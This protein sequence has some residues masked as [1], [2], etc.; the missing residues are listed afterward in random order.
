VAEGPLKVATLVWGVKQSFRNYVQGAGGAIETHGGVVCVDGEFVFAASPDGGLSRDSA[1]ALH[2]AQGFTGE[3]AFKAH[4]G[5]LSVR[6]IDPAVEITEAGAVLSAADGSKPGARY[7]MVT[8]D[9]NAMTRDGSGAIVI[10]TKLT[11]DGAYW[12]GDNYPPMTP[13]DPVRLTLVS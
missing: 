6:L 12:L 9:L 7:P 1:G 2:G 4:G 11:G 8:L 3:V 10:P 5:M 13:V